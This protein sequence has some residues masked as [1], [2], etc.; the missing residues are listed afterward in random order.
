MAIVRV[1][2]LI[3]ARSSTNAKTSCGVGTA[4]DL[5]ALGAGEKL[6]ALLNILSSS[7]GGLLVRVQSATSSG[8]AAPNNEVTFTTRSC[9]S[10]QWATP[11]TTATVSSTEPVFW[12]AEY[13]MTTSGEAYQFV[14]SMGRQ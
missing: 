1:T 14:P 3:D 9:V 7:T 5:G 12:R 13:G 10:A 6:Y 11:L 8:F 4:F 2:P